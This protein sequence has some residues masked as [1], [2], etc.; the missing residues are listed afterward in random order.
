VG[1]SALPRQLWCIVTVK[2]TS[3]STA[4]NSATQT[5]RIVYK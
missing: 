5:F 4:S 1:I 3:V 2:V